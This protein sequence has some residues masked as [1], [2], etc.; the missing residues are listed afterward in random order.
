LGGDRRRR[1]DSLGVSVKDPIVTKGEF[2]SL[3]FS[4]VSGGDAALP[5]L[6]WDFLLL[7]RHHRSGF[8]CGP[9]LHTEPTPYTLLELTE[10]K[11]S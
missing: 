10:R 9:I 11:L 1:R 5:K 4:A 2:V 3:F 6:L 8:S 7:Y